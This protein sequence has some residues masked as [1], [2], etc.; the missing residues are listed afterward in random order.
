MTSMTSTRAEGSERPQERS[1]EPESVPRIM[2]QGVRFR[3]GSILLS[4]GENV[5][6]KPAPQ[7]NHELVHVGKAREQDRRDEDVGNQ[8]QE[9]VAG[10]VFV[11][12]R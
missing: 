8:E 11:V 2:S 1:S 10:T 9:G 7:C 3:K 12:V 6:G 4:N 5:Q